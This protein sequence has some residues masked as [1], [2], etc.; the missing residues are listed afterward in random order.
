MTLLADQL[1]SMRPMRVEQQ[2]TRRVA[3]FTLWTARHGLLG[4]G[5]ALVV[6]LF[7]SMYQLL[8]FGL[9]P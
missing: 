1:V 9:V 2:T 5:L 7:L 4:D 3:T 6:Y 8:E